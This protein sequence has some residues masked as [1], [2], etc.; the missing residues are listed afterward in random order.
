MKISTVIPT[1]NRRD[2]V[3]RAIK[4]VL[5][6][7]VAVDEII[8]VDDGST[9]GTAEA[10]GSRYGSSVRLFRQKNGG[11][12]AARNRGI[13]EARGEWIALLDSDDIWLPTK[14]E[15]QFTA[16]DK[17]GRECRVCFTDN[18]FDGDPDMQSS[19]FQETSFEGVPGFGILG[20]PT[21]SVMQGTQPFLLQAFWFSV[22]L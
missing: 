22:R 20:E 15:R 13:R 11:V 21:V 3:L 19:R 9:D 7:T 14:I 17:F 12:A 6:Q 4:S 1:Y 16:V 8:V 10:I 18:M 2:H 5:A